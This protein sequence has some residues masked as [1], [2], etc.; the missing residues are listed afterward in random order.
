MPRL[1]LHEQV[2]RAWPATATGALRVAFGIV[3]AVSAAITFTPQFA[4]HY[5]GY[6]HNAA[7]GQPA[8]L[9]GWFA[10]WIG[11]VTPNAAL[12][13]WLTRLIECAIALGLLA[14]VAR[15]SI[16]VAGALFSLVIWST[17]GGFGGPYTVGATNM[18]AALA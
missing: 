16:Y 12:F 14:G 13:I 9:A 3:W 4:H 1:S 5:V 2:S 15:R 7:Q 18:G 8:W 6:L 10:M 11:L 17:A